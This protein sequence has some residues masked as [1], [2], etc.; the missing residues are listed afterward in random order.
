MLISSEPFNTNAIQTVGFKI[1]KD[2]ENIQ[3]EIFC[4]TGGY[5]SGKYKSLNL[6]YKVDDD[7]QHVDM[8][9][10]LVSEML[11]LLPETVFFPDQCH[12]ANISIV[13]KKTINLK[14]T[15]ALI[16]DKKG[17][18]IGV[19]AADCVPVVF[20][21]PLRN[22]VAVAHAG[23]KGTVKGIVRNVVE[24]MVEVFKCKPKNIISGIGPA[25]SQKNYEV[26]NEVV[27]EVLKLGND[28]SRFVNQVMDKKYLDLKG[29]NKQILLNAGLMEENIEINPLCTFDNPDI[30]YSARRDGFSCG[31][32]G[33]L[34][35]LK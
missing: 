19:L 23:W 5:S 10:Y 31:R 21:D 26:G 28:Y 8:N 3:C 33:T 16:T 17:I 6:S 20:Y 4:R 29:V 27:Q 22:I 7:E 34:I 30:F 2:F 1:Y 32:F 25:I 13:E 12:T 15:D 14:E 18:A 11:G 35:T 9:R 24:K